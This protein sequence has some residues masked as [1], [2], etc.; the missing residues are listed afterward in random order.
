VTRI[1]VRIRDY[2]GAVKNCP[3]VTCK[4]VRRGPSIVT[5][6]CLPLGERRFPEGKP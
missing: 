1:D 3:C 2:A 6:T 5:I 4:S